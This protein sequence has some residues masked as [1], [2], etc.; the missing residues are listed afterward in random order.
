[1]GSVNIII[2]LLLRLSRFLYTD[3]DGVVEWAN[4][5]AHL[6]TLKYKSEK[7]DATVMIPFHSNSYMS[8]FQAAQS[9][10]NHTASDSF[11]H[12][13]SSG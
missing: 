7:E 8:G 10:V 12:P 13:E 9:P 11:S 5:Q 4:E 6:E 1:M 3:R 2:Q